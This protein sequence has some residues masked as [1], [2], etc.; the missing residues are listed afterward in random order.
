MVGYLR[1]TNRP[2]AC[3][4]ALILLALSFSVLISVQVSA[5][6]LQSRALHILSPVASQ[7]TTHIFKFTY[8]TT[9]DPV[10]SVKFEYCTSP[11]PAIPCDAPQGIDVSGATLVSQTGESGFSVVGT[12]QNSIILSRGTALPVTASASE[13]TLENVINPDGVPS[14]FYARIT[15]HQST[16][17][18]GAE[19]DYGSVVNAITEG[20]TIGGE[21]PPLLNFCVGLTIGVDCSSADGNLIDLGDLKTNT[22]SSG[23]SQMLAYTNAEFGLAIGVYGTTMTSG[24]NEIPALA[25]P[26]PSAPGNA[27][28]GFNLRS[29]SNPGKG[30]EPSGPGVTAPTAGYNIPN[31]YSFNSGDIVAISSE[32][33]DVRKFTSTYIVNVSPNQQPGV[34]TSTLTYICT[35][36]F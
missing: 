20:V 7:E 24:I 6:Q 12:T 32:A 27:Q 9:S 15:T 16:D 26:T 4:I 10:G 33:T 30:E 18:T 17:G 1:K 19:S 8:V 23:T 22:V 21:V 14:T 5:V 29:N 34:Y 28:F 35:A 11:I 25:N 31:R 36:T 3:F 13:Y 2:F